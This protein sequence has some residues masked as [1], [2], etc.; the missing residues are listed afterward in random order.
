MQS[1]TINKLQQPTFSLIASFY[2]MPPDVQEVFITMMALYEQTPSAEKAAA[3]FDKVM[4]KESPDE[5]RQWFF[6]QEAKLT[7]A[8]RQR[9]EEK[10]IQNRQ[11]VPK[12][13]PTSG[14]LLVG[15]GVVSRADKEQLMDAQAAARIL[16]HLENPNRVHLSQELFATNTTGQMGEARS[17][18]DKPFS[19]PIQR[20][21]HLSA[22][23]AGYQVVQEPYR[24]VAAQTG[25][26]LASVP[27]IEP[28]LK[29]F[30]KAAVDTLYQ[31]SEHLSPVSGDVA[32]QI[33]KLAEAYAPKD[34]V[35]D[36]S[37]KPIVFGMR[38]ILP[39]LFTWHA[40]HLDKAKVNLCEDSYTPDERVLVEKL[41]QKR[42]TQV[43]SGLAMAH[44][45]N[46]SAEK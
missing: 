30:H 34:E 43:Q 33:R 29:E 5:K 26:L 20:L 1:D 12:G 27:S 7:M 8:D 46:R 4:G 39:C 36:W 21:E 32:A 44:V 38:S 42:L 14:N 35:Q 37:M 24:K 17:Y 2:P 18:L 15:L 23:L 10:Y 40:P 13:L 11:A 31:V 41:V 9:A 6:N 19:T 45:P 3:L 25:D 16:D 28:A 22:I